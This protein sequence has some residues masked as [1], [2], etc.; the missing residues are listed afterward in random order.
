MLRML[1]VALAGLITTTGMLATHGAANTVVRAS[2]QN[3]CHK[4]GRVH[5]HSAPPATVTSTSWSHPTG[6]PAGTPAI[7]PA[8]IQ[9]VPGRSQSSTIAVST[10]QPRGGTSNVLGALNAQRARSGVGTLRFDPQLQA[11][12]EQRAA[13]MASQGLKNHPPGSF[14]PGTYEGVGW[15]SSY[16]PS[17]VSACFTNDPR[18]SVAGAAMATGRDGVYFCVVY[19]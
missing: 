12:A 1:S 7:G 8:Q 5:S 9:S 6:I 11:V 18:M 14:A 13:L 2:Q 3:F 17:G 19:R 15:S 4:C 10:M 16:S